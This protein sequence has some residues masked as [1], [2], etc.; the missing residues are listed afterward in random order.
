MIWN[1]IPN[2][3]LHLM[4]CS[5]TYGGQKRIKTHPQTAPGIFFLVSNAPGCAKFTTEDDESN[6]IPNEDVEISTWSKCCRKSEKSSNK[7][8]V[9]FVEK[10]GWAAEMEDS[11]LVH[12]KYTPEN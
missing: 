3:G 9:F 12:F 5:Y 4:S 10:N 6:V 1:S 2:D 8:G 11:N 7:N